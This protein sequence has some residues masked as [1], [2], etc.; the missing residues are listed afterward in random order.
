MR[1]ELKGGVLDQLNEGDKE[2]PGVRPVHNQSLQQHPAN[3]DNI[4]WTDFY[5]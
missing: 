4:Y 3:R 5:Y 1:P 2:P